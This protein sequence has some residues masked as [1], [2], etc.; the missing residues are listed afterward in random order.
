MARSHL[1][2]DSSLDV[3]SCAQTVKD[4][5]PID[6]AAAIVHGCHSRILLVTYYLTDSDGA[7]ALNLTK[8]AR[9]GAFVHTMHLPH[10][11][12]GDL[13]MTPEQLVATK[14]VLPHATIT[15]SS[16]GRTIDF[17]VISP[18][19]ARNAEL[20]IDLEAPCCTT[21]QPMFEA[22]PEYQPRHDDHTIATTSFA[23]EA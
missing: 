8:L 10:V 1:R 11:I 19:L 2:I 16:G 5:E 3:S 6:F 12:V 9:L 13:N 23:L 4:H 14:V 21:Q 18:V 7:C 15:C 20:T 22:A 17:A